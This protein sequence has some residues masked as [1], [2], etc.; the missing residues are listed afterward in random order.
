MDVK[1]LTNGIFVNIDTATKY[2]PSPSV[3]DDINNKRKEH[4]SSS[5]IS[6]EYFP[7]NQDA[8]RIVVITNYNSRTH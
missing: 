7:L 6:K 3:L 2:F 5:D 4:W 8:K 1:H